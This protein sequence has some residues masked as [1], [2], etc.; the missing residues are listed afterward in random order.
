[1][2]KRIDT[3]A[4]AGVYHDYRWTENV[5]S[6]GEDDP[7]AF[8]DVNILYGRNYSG[9][10]TLSRLARALELRQMPPKLTQATFSFAFDA[11]SITQAD[12]ATHTQIVRVFNE[13][14][15]RENLSVLH[16]DEGTITPFA[17]LGAENNAVQAQI[18]ELE[19]K[20]GTA[21]PP[22][23]L[24]GEQ[25]QSARELTKAQAELK[26]VSDA[27]DKKLAEKANSKPD[28]IKHNKDYGDP[29]YQVPRLREDLGAVLADT[30]SPLDDAARARAITDLKE[31]AKAPLPAHSAPM[32]AWANVLDSAN[33]ALTRVVQPSAP[34]QELL[35]D[36]LLQD[37]VRKGR[38]LHE[39]K[40][41][42]CGFCGS[43]LPSGLWAQLDAHFNQQ[44][45]ALRTELDNV[46]GKAAGERA[47]LGAWTMPDA[48]QLY[49]EFHA[50]CLALKGRKEVATTSYE[51]ALT[52]IETA[53]NTR[54]SDV[55]KPAE[56]LKLDD[57][58]TAVLDTHAAIE[59][60]KK[61]S[62]AHTASLETRRA[63]AA[64]ALRL[65]DV[66]RWALDYCYTE[67][68]DAVASLEKATAEVE[69]HAQ[70]LNAR[71]AGTQAQV[72]ALRAQMKDETRGAECVND[73]L[74]NA[75]GHKT[76]RLAP[77]PTN[78]GYR[79][80]IRR[81]IEVATHLSQGECSLL[82]FCYF[83][84]K[85][86]DVETADAKPLVWIDD[87]VSSLDANHV[88][89]LFSL[90]RFEIL[91]KKR[92][93]QLFISTH[94]LDFLKFVM[95]VG[96]STS[97]L[98]IGYFLIERLAEWSRLRLMPLY[99]R[100]QVSEFIYLFDYIHRCAHS[101]DDAD[102]EERLVSFANNA[103]KFLEIY[104]A[105][106]Y[107]GPGSDGEKL[108]RFFGPGPGAALI[109]RILHEY[110]HLG[111]G[112]ERALLTLDV[113][114]MRSSAKAIVDRI[115]EVDPPQFAAF[116]KAIGV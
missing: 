48:E 80:E 92:C 78:G 64:K 40:R 61:S 112:F 108:A 103:R 106:R 50:E 4:N 104:L 27:F 22:V 52:A 93:S 111:G 28:G 84:A 45:E 63:Q 77:V 12:L 68:R 3:I 42:T 110:S 32:L 39:H 24:L 86:S 37:W 18:G 31:E 2:L 73:L 107:P 115:A 87:P 95:K 75:F 83:V 69:A 71:I 9:K 82:A 114:E 16:L 56:A 41:E 54:L 29:N 90:I 89:F 70:V 10:T 30:Y 19:K 96:P 58:E 23:G 55:F 79:F 33:Q 62:N 94:H 13:D 72:A 35:N 6:T 26:K 43:P 65:D 47:M 60:L 49:G 21:E 51:A 17:V 7:A 74:A 36:A 14:F 38:P 15:V 53:V 116:K 46:I 44:S 109:E 8:Q 25:A 66:R 101:A 34:L 100:K 11:G 57:P 85:L 97:K 59:A 76:L 81:G 113:M 99:F 1:M 5:I 20:L 91:R 105:F 67:R 88:F 102:A 98:K